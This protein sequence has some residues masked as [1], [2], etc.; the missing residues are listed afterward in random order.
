MMSRKKESIVS[1]VMAGALLIAFLAT[2]A[3]CQTISERMQASPMGFP[4]DVA[5]A[6]QLWSVLS[7]EK[8]VGPDRKKTTP[9]VG[10]ARPHGWIL[11][12]LHQNITVGTHTGFIVVKRNYDG[13]GV[14]VATVD[15]DRARYLSSVTIMFQRESG[16]DEDNL[17]WFW[18]K[19]KPDGSLFLKEI[20]EI[21][22]M[23][24]M[25]VAL[26]GRIAKGKTPGKS[27]GCIYCHRSAGGGD[28][29]FYP[30]IKLPGFETR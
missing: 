26:A 7:E 6:N 23:K 14:S 18:A 24:G 13:P 9:F 11:E 19:Y 20:K 29:I 8:L 5:Y 12:L 17:N 3:A 22:E 10:A 28:Y 25:K 15:A 21:K 2:I 16:Y 1:K 30:E 4:D 27:S